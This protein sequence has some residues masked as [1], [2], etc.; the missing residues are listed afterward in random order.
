MPREAQ[1]KGSLHARRGESGQRGRHGEGVRV[2]WVD[3]RLASL[4]SFCQENVRLW[5]GLGSGLV[6]RG[7]PEATSH[8]AGALGWLFPPAREKLKASKGRNG[9]T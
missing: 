1:R 8:L 9:I 3:C 5:L 7:G 4:W 6:A 2:E